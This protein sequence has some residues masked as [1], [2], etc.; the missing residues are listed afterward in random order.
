MDLVVTNP[1]IRFVDRFVDRRYDITVTD[2]NRM[3]NN[4]AVVLRNT[5]FTRLFLERWA[6]I[7]A[8][9]RELKVRGACG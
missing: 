3:L 7:S 9:N 5:P 6:V 8:R 2:H 4:G 1:S